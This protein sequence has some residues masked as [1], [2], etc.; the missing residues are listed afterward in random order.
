MI[1]KRSFFVFV[2]TEQLINL[3][4]H[5]IDFI[6][7]LDV[8]YG[9]YKVLCIHRYILTKFIPLFKTFFNL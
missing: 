5:R 9:F 2:Q 1:L 8:D 6:L 4:A 7:M 3:K